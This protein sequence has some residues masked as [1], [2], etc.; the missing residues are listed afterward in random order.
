[1][2]TESRHDGE[3]SGEGL[4]LADDR[5]LMLQGVHNLRDFGGYPVE[6]GGRL[7]RGRLWRS[8]QHH[9]AS[10]A[11]LLAIAGLGLT[12]VYDLRT[13]KERAAHPCRRPAGFMATVD[14]PESPS[15]AQ[16]PHLAA[17]RTAPRRYDVASTRES[18]R[19]NYEGIAFRPQLTAVIGRMLADLA[20]GE[21]AVLV[22]CMAGKDR[23][24]I[25][26]AA[27]HLAVGVHRDDILA[28]YLLTN[29]AGDVEA[30]IRD[31][32]KVIAALTGELDLAVV[33]VLMSVEAEYLETAFAAMRERYGSE[34]GWLATELGADAAL[35]ER[36]R[37]QLVER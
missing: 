1:M 3:L 8:G 11:D 5:V 17:A 4:R 34:E 37:A 6:G 20:A 25:A 26:V 31:G 7:K 19:R 36:L 2:E 14:H 29:T 21:R 15:L 27:V 18:L 30:R 32:A 23:T 35:R 16:V 33:R 10:D 9:A 22:N 13:D 12:K 28:D 24:G